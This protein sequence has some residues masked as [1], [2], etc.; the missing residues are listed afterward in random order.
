MAN[1]EA[2]KNTI[3]ITLDYKE[4]SVV[5]DGV[6]VKAHS[7][8]LD[9]ILGVVRLFEITYE[10]AKADGKTITEFIANC[11]EAYAEYNE[12]ADDDDDDDDDDED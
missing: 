8:T 12:I 4:G 6:N 7:T 1:K 5:P 11:A 9:A 3:K 10:K 2:H